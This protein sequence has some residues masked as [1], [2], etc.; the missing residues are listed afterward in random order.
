MR[1]RTMQKIYLFFSALLLVGCQSVQ[2]TQPGMVGVDRSQAMLVSSSS[3]NEGAVKA[4]RQV[5][6]E[7]QK[8]NELNQE[9]AQVERIR[10]IAR[11]LIAQT[12]VFRTDAP[13]W[14]W[15]VNVITSKELNAWC[16]PG[17][18]IAFYTG[19]LDKLQLT[20][21]EA[22]AIMGHEIAHALREHGRERASRSMAQGIFF[23]AVSIMARLPAGSVDLSQQ[24]MDL[25]FNLPNSRTDETEADHIG[26]ELAARA[27]FDPQAAIRVWEKMKRVSRDQSPQFLS[28]HPSHDTRIADLQTM[29]Q[30]VQPLYETARPKP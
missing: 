29:V 14:A 26:V 21:D 24:V 8:K 7:A 11:R 10:A 2:T 18:K 27:G 6:A 5:L 23:S 4:Y 28:T 20:D 9:P 30:R 12:G 22:A 13:R 16:M 1:K 17:G 25:T 15:E 3:V 19:I